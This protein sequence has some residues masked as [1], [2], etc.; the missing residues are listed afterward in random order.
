MKTI[1]IKG[2]KRETLGRKSSNQDRKQGLVPCVIYGAG[3][4]NVHF[5]APEAS[6]KH[7]VYTPQSHMVEID[8]DGQHYNAILKDVQY[9]PVS[10]KIEHIDFLQI[11][12]DKKVVINVPVKLH[13]FP[14]GVKE[15]GKLSQLK[16]KVK[17]S[18]FMNDLP[19]TI[20]LNV[21]HLK[22][23]HSVKIQDLKYDNVE[24]LDLKNAVVASV[25][26]TRAVVEETTAAPGAEGA[27]TAATATAAT[28]AATTTPAA[29]KKEKPT[30]KK[31]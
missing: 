10:E 29:D 20:N 30:D 15:G 9:H 21:D 25:K 2:K 8:I 24:F 13:G 28:P 4:E 16:R 23:G 5:T 6:F 27:A 11:Y 18:A 31:K 12:K 3:S 7:L 17:V 19:E 22:I 1:E 14:I 26:V